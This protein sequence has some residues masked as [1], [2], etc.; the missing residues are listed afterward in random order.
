MS[1]STAAGVSPLSADRNQ[2]VSDIAK[3]FQSKPSLKRL[4][5]FRDDALF[6]D[7]IAFA[8]GRQYFA[9]QWYGMPK[10][11]PQ[12]V[13]KSINVTKNDA[14]EINLDVVQEYT[15]A[16]IGKKVTIPSNIVIQLDEQ[17]KI[18]R[19]ADEWHHK[20]IPSGTLAMMGR[21]LN[22]VMVKTFVSVPKKDDPAK[23][24]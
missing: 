23:E 22:A 24:D 13:T 9:P 21:K 15:V 7:P 16:L 10:A 1:I 5:H 19:L 4:D 2:L 6:E 20:P 14:N 17:G 3:L 18:T 8:K 12:S 11:F